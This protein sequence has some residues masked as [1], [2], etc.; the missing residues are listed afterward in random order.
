MLTRFLPEGLWQLCEGVSEAQQSGDGL[1]KKQKS[2]DKAPRRI[3][4]GVWK[5]NVGGAVIGAIVGAY[6]QATFIP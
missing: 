1:A 3:Q 2:A 5:G 6:L 4:S